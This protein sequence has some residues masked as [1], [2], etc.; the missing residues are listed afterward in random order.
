MSYQT[1]PLVYSLMIYFVRDN[2]LSSLLPS[3]DN[4]HVRSLDIY[5]IVDLWKE[6]AVK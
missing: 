6:T 2:Y 4:D 1:T 3:D 5:F